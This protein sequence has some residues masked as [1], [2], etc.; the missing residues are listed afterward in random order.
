M[1]LKKRLDWLES[2]A[3]LHTAGMQ[4]LFLLIL[5][6]KERAQRQRQRH[7]GLLDQRSPLHGCEWQIAGIAGRGRLP[8]TKGIDIYGLLMSYQGNRQRSTPPTAP[9]INCPSGDALIQRL[10]QSLAGE[11]AST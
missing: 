2:I 7:N 4:A 9:L 6:T 5:K 1:N 10:E 11:G 8:A 3:E